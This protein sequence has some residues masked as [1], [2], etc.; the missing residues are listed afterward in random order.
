VESNLNNNVGLLKSG[1]LQHRIMLGTDGMHSDMLRAAQATYLVEQGGGVM[2]PEEVYR[3]F[4]LVHRYLAAGGFHGGGPDSVLILDYPS[5][6][7]VTSDNFLG[8]F[9]FG[10]RAPHVESVIAGGRF[11]VRDRRVVT[12]DETEVLAFTR[13]M[14]RKLWRTMEERR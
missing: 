1:G 2:S 5:R 13:E 14:G 7:E 11:I 9:V 6:T 10:L 3:R 8:H 12:V 4:R